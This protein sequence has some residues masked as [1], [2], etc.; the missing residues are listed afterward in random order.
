MLDALTPLRAPVSGDRR[1]RLSCGG[2]TPSL[3]ALRTVSSAGHR[4]ARGFP[5]RREDGTLP[6]VIRTPALARTAPAA[7][8]AFVAAIFALVLGAGAAC[9]PVVE[10][11]GNGVD[12]DDD[13]R[14]DCDDEACA[15]DSVCGGCGDGAVDV[16]E[17]CD[18]GNVDD[19]D[20]CS[21][22]CLL[23]HCG[24]G[25]L[26]PGE[27]C[28][29]GNLVGGDGCDARCQLG[30]CGDG[31]LELDEE[32]EDGNH[33]SGDGCDASCHAEFTDCSQQRDIQCIDGNAR[34]GDG[35][36]ATC[37]SEFCG[38][39][40]VQPTLGERCD[41][42]ARGAAVVGCRGCQMTTP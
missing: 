21:A 13:G 24:D 11:C 36:S 34:S 27:A 38:D 19:G 23:E 26:D 20:G 6:I 12:D 39:G 29:D 9:Q 32:C 16:G 42:N 18:D 28:D 25:V 15:F 10:R 37:R 35:C 2:T 40:I 17:A 22:R 14:V 3:R 30:R 7:P 31:V 8:S 5:A 4:R 41:D 33:D 1:R